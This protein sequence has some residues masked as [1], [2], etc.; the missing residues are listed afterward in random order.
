MNRFVRTA[1]GL[2]A[3]L[4]IS[5]GTLLPAAAAYAAQPAEIAASAVAAPEIT[6]TGTMPNVFYRVYQCS[7]WTLRCR[8]WYTYQSNGPYNSTVPSVYYNTYVWSWIW[9]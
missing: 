6:I 1:L 3:G 2:G 4:A 8:Y 7:N 9:I 5:L